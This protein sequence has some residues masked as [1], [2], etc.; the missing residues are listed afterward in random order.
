MKVFWITLSGV[1][2]LGL[3]VA[4]V[5]IFAMPSEERWVDADWYLA[6]NENTL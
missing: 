3:F 4:A 5:C 2:L 1:C 6:D